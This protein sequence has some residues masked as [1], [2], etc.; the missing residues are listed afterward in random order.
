M[1]ALLVLEDVEI[2]YGDA[3]LAVRG[4]S[5]SVGQ[6]KIIALLGANGAGKSST[7]R[8][9]SNLLH[10][11]RGRVTGGRIS[12][13]GAGTAGVATS[14][15]VAA[16]LVQVVE[17]RHCFRALTVEENLI[18]GAIGRQAT[19]A[20]AAHD[21]ARVYDLFPRLAVKRK[22]AAGLTS[23]GEQQMTAIGRAL[24]ARPR[25]LVLD[26]PSM[27]LAPIV[28]AEIF[29]TLAALNRDDGLTILLAEQNAAVALRHA[30]RAVVLENGRIA[31][32][33]RAADLQRRDDIRAAYLG[34]E[35]S[36]PATVPAVPQ[37]HLNEVAS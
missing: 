12:F 15:L 33:G 18:T 9:V 27:G 6:G 37:F 23:G 36:R 4:V 8:A 28:V 35:K 16:G 26:E 19:R 29:R 32:E 31:L 20:E 3:I 24:M 14:R 22:L 21:L 25:L 30:H 5:F 7:L 13:D 1:T 17:G 2:A 11:R 34:F 10:A